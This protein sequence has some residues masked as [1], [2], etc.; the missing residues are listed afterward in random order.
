MQLAA[1]EVKA[2][3]IAQAEQALERG[4]AIRDANTDPNMNDHW[5]GVVKFLEGRL[6]DMEE[7]E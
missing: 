5:D 4:K 7:M 3:A 6:K 2:A 1:E